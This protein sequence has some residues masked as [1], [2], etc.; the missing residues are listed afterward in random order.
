MTGRKMKKSFVM[1]LVLL[2]FAVTALAG[3]SSSKKNTSPTDT[4]KNTTSTPSS[5]I[6]PA[7]DTSKFVTLTWY[8]PPPL[9]PRPNEEKV[10]KYLNAMLKEKLNV[11]LVFKFVDSAT[12]AQRIKVAAAAGEEFD[13]FTDLNILG[14]SQIVSSGMAFELDDLINKYGQDI[15]KKVPEKAWKAVTSKGKKYGIAN[16]LPWV[17]SYNFAFRK[18]LVDKYKIDYAKI[19]NYKDLEP[20]LKMLKEKEPDLIPF[21]G[22]VF[23]PQTM[24]NISTTIGYDT[25]DGKWKS[26]LDNKGWLDMVKLKHDW[27]VKGYMPKKVIADADAVTEFKTGRYATAGYH[28]YDASFVKTSTDFGT[29]MV[30]SLQDLKTVVT[31]SSIRIVVSHISKT[32][33]NPERAMMLLNLLYADK[34]VFNKFAY[35]VEGDDWDYVSG[36]GTDNP[37]VKTKD[38]LGWAMWHPWIANLWDQWPS[39]WNSQEVLDGLKSAIDKADYSPLSGFVFDSTPVKKELA[40]LDAFAP[41]LKIIYV[42]NDVD[43]KIAEYKEKFAK[44]GLDVVLAEVQKQVDAWKATNVK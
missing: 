37:T 33:K 14:F 40:Q 24:D 12:Y 17:T 1:L 42:A 39:N 43:S 16:P 27:Y 31:G 4:V 13:I 35:G 22:N 10:M 6:T 15:V 26:H 30:A 41:E 28:V 8:M 34:N 25:T 19:H 9:D 11:N 7:V 2:L 18:D 44:A 36:K 5:T 38:K 23:E 20:V 29:P 32:S 3:C 21:V